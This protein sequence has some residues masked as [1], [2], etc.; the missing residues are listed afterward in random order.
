MDIALKQA[1]A[2]LG[3]GE[4]PVGCVIAAGVNV[5]AS[6]AR[7]GSASHTGSETDHAEIMA[8]RHLNQLSQGLDR[9]IDPAGLTIYCTLEPCL[10]CFGAILIHGIRHIVYAC[11]DPMGGGTRCDRSTLPPIY[12]KADLTII[13][14]V[15]DKESR[16]LFRTFFENPDN[17]YL[18]D[19]L[20]ARHMLISI[21]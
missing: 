14:G 16:G 2:A 7:D 1:Q 15:R 6:G 5:I 9:P 11:E 21:P 12:S 17:Q 19:T 20:L 18:Q 13:T 4:F 3:R 10:M 8:L